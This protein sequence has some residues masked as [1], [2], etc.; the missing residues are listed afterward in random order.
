MKKFNKVLAVILSLVMLFSVIPAAAFAAETP[1]NG[2]QSSGGVQANKPVSTPATVAPTPT[3]TGADGTVTLTV[4]VSKLLAALKGE[5]TADVFLQ[6]LKDM[7]SG[8]NAFTMDDL[9][10]IVPINNLIV[11]LFGD[12]N[13]N[14]SDLIE[15]LGGFEEFTEMVDI[16][17]LVATADRSQLADFVLESENIAA[18]FADVANDKEELLKLFGQIAA[19]ETALEDVVDTGAL[20]TEIAELPD[21]EEAYT[22]LINIFGADNTVKQ[23]TSDLPELLGK[24]SPEQSKTLITAVLSAV[25]RSLE[26][27]SVDGYEIIKASGEGLPSVNYS[28]LMNALNA[29]LPTLDELANTDGTLCSFNLYIDYNV[30]AENG[31]DVAKRTKDVNINIVLDGDLTQFKRIVAKLA[32]YISVTNNGNQ[33]SVELTVPAAVAAAYAKLLNSDMDA[34]LKEKLVAMLGKDVSD[35]SAALGNLSLDQL[36][37]VLSMISPEDVYAALANTSFVE[38]ILEKVVSATG[39]DLESLKDLTNVMHLLAN[40]KV[41]LE[42]VCEL[43]EKR[44]GQDVMALLEKVAVKAD[45]NATV[46]AYLDKLAT[47]PY[48]GTLVAGLTPSEILEA[49][50]G[51]NLLIAVS[52]AVADR[53]G[54]DIAQKLATE[55]ADALWQEALDRASDYEGYYN[56]VRDAIVSM[57]DPNV[58]P[59]NSLAAKLKGLIP[60]SVLKKLFASSLTDLYRGNGT[61]SASAPSISLDLGAV[62]RKL[63]SVLYK[64]IPAAEQYS[65]I[66]EKFLPDSTVNFGI[67]LKVNFTNIYQIGRAH[68]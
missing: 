17:S 43:I 31:T 27:V 4:S 5:P 48:I 54:E 37:S 50:K 13:E 65:D 44:V 39:L 45:D 33:I 12:N 63:V 25:L 53:V 38:V 41:T 21:K 23:L 29:V 2:S 3:G 16:D 19:G 52:D 24:L 55:D 14:A 35:W 18:L 1:T 46:Q 32:Q 11:L 47:V 62:C 67:N 68:V 6:L 15:Q 26:F 51:V 64:G 61:F 57:I 49:Y 36:V 59:T 40:D 9:L 56:R 58:A 20:F 60:E 22:D 8:N 7:V 34:A 10:E 66:I 28:G 42:K 30:R